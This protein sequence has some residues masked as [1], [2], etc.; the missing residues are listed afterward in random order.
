VLDTG[1]H[2]NTNNVNK[3]GALLQTTGE[4]DEPNILL[5]DHEKNTTW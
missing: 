5:V 1:Y 3:I 2:Y 4:K